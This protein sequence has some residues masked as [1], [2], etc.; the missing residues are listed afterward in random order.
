M[1][2][3]GTLLSWD[4]NK[5]FGFI[6]P[7]GG[8]AKLFVHISVMRG[9]AR[10]QQGDNVLYLVGE[11]ERGRPRAT[12]MRGEALSLDKASIRRKPREAVSGK[13]EKPVRSA[14]RPP[15]AKTPSLRHSSGIR[16]LPLKLGVWSLLCILPLLGSL[17]FYREQGWIVPLVAYCA[18][19]LI[20]FLMYRSDKRSAQESRQ[21]TPEN[22]LHLSELLGGWPGALIA[23][24]RF[25]HKTRKASYQTI[26][27]MIVVAHQLYWA[28]RLLL[29]GRYLVRLLG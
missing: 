28:D 7:E 21:R 6:Q 16:Q 2:Q 12:H 13:R 5:G 23:Q 11:D 18:A 20:S 8:G 24:Q 25:R 4:D 19:S 15:K 9:D 14:S 1:E 29:E 22:M 10:P 17:K 3:R 26:F 27:W